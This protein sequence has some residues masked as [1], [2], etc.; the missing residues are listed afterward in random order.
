[1]KPLI[2]LDELLKNLSFKMVKWKFDKDIEYIVRET[3]LIT[4]YGYYKPANAIDILRK[5]FY[6]FVESQLPKQYLEYGQ[7]KYIEIAKRP[8]TL[9]PR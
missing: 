1:M 8:A 9:T 7:R 3:V 5:R 4:G 2:A 6:A